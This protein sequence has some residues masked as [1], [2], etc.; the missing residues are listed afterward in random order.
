M[1]MRMRK[2]STMSTRLGAGRCWMRMRDGCPQRRPHTSV[3]RKQRICARFAMVMALIRLS[4]P[5]L[6]TQRICS[7]SICEQRRGLSFRSVTCQIVW[8][9]KIRGLSDCI[10]D[11]SLAR[12][13]RC[14]QSNSNA[15]E[16]S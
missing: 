2:P 13:N 4:G 15:Y 5:Q 9:G 3:R 8:I 14:A 16:D 11:A 7:A 10:P 12:N 1:G 6:L